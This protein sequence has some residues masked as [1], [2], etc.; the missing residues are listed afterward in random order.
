MSGDAPSF[1][2]GSVYR[3]ALLAVAM[4]WSLR[5]VGL[6]SVFILA[7]LLSPA[8]FGM[9]GLA[10]ATVALVELFSVI[11]LRQALLRIPD[12]ERSHLD[13]AWT[14]Q[15]LMFGGLSAILVAVA[16]VAAW[17]YGEP[18][19]GPVIAVLATRF[20]LLGLVNI[21]IVDFDRNLDFGR[22][23]RMRL[24]SRILSFVATV[25]AALLLRSYWALIIGLVLQSALFALSSYR[26]HP[27]RPHFSLARRRELLGVSGWMFLN[28]SAQVVHHQ[29]ERLVL[30]RF[31]AMHLIGLYSVSKDLA[32]IFTQEIATA[33]NRVT[34]VTTSRSGRPLSESADRI[35]ATLGAY[36]MIAAPLGLGLAATSQ[37]AVAVLLGAQWIDAAPL[38]RLIAPASALYAVYK[39]IA[40]SLQASGL[41]RRGALLTCAGAAAAGIALAATAW[42]GGGAA[43]LAVT[44]LAVAA[45]LL[46]VGT[47]VL[48]LAARTR[49][50]ALGMN[51]VRPFAAAAAMLMAVRA[52]GAPSGH[53]LPDLLLQVTLGA[54]AYGAALL[55]I[56]FA[57][58]RPAGAEAQGLEVM[59]QLARRFERRTLAGK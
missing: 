51:I 25:A 33:L 20:L 29:L 44:A 15:L 2:R 1:D 41:E 26:A 31:G 48:A 22:D 42:A 19:L 56:W 54:A 55:L 52:V 39:V 40:S 9:A 18:A 28:F 45:G 4:T 21:G 11:G 58:G 35:G 10:M 43:A 13:T 47:L 5:L 38:L 34:F 59:M 46:A 23:M 7:R 12:P 36:A 49:A 27:Y 3:G 50:F 30:G 14:I 16:P 24:S 32:S 6:F 37:Q 17:L 8:D 57:C 53:V